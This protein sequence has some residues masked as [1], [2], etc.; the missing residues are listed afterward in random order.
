MENS[1]RVAGWKDYFHN[2]CMRINLNISD[3]CNFSCSYCINRNVHKKHRV[4]K[5]ETLSHF[6]EDLGE[7]NRDSYYFGISGGEPLI[8]P[9]IEF[10]LEKI[11]S[12]IHTD[13][14]YVCILS[15]GSLLPEKGKYLYEKVDK[16]K[17]SFSISVHIEQIDLKKFCDSIVSFGHL[18]DLNCKI[19]LAPGY[20]EQAKRSLEMLRERDI[21]I[22]IGPV[23]SPAG[24][25]Y[26]FS[27]E[28]IDFLNQF[29]DNVK[30]AVFFLEYENGSA[31]DIF[32][33]AKGL[34]PEKSDFYGMRCLAGRNSLG[35][36]PDGIVRRCFW[37]G[38]EFFDLNETRLRDIPELNQPYICPSHFCNCHA[39]LRMPKWIN[40]KDAPDYL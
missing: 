32:R 25:P 29:K 27:D 17:L 21:P 35:L 13:N 38:K 20:L 19:L 7:R 9:H 30:E 33:V 15:N 24:Q 36:G 11:E 1:I 14:K 23:T 18:D 4:L 26:E 2:D 34:H 28:E 8:Y 22:I 5:K 6:I 37:A 3:I 40:D 16:T 12:A 10:M 31:E 39:F